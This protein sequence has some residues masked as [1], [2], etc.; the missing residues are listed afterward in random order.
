[1]KICIL[2]LAATLCASAEYLG[3]QLV[4]DRHNVFADTVMGT[5]STEWK[6]LCAMAKIDPANARSVL[7]SLDAWDYF[8]V[9]NKLSAFR[10]GGNGSLVGLFESDSLKNVS[11]D[12][13]LIASRIAV[14]N[15]LYYVKNRGHTEI[16]RYVLSASDEDLAGLMGA[17]DD[18]LAD[19]RMRDAKDTARVLAVLVVTY[20]WNKNKQVQPK[21]E[22]VEARPSAPV[23]K[24]TKMEADIDR[25]TKMVN[26]REFLQCIERLPEKPGD[27]PDSDLLREFVNN[28]L[29]PN[30]KSSWWI[31]SPAVQKDIRKSIRS[32]A[33]F[34]PENIALFDGSR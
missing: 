29:I 33:F 25:Y 15:I 34:S 22:R 6:T 9:S 17:K 21:N 20:E 19:V 23:V 14:M 8:E 27:D 12:V 7:S 11:D 18:K 4:V 30:M 3:R 32:T 13:G 28:T 5:G 1:M 2:L 31:I 10:T 16:L 26:R 24:R